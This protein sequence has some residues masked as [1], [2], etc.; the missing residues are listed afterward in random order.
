MS[1]LANE[2]CIPCRGDVPP[3]EG[4]ELDSF[5]SRLG[6]DWELIDRHHLS[7]TFRFPDFR[8][9][10]DFTNQ[11]GELAESVDHHPDIYL[12]WGQ[13]RVEIWTHK[14]DGLTSADFVF[15]AKTTALK[16]G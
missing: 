11:V 3:L 8:Q 10:L 14:V 7:C 13:V 2:E 1:E 9:A 16:E 5:M 15:A 12:A 4:E 6:G